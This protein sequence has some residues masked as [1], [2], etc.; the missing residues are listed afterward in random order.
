MRLILAGA[1]VSDV[2]RLLKIDAFSHWLVVLPSVTRKVSISTCSPSTET[3]DVDE[4]LTEEE[5]VAER[6]M[7]EVRDEHVGYGSP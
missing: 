6:G 3:L 1:R 7:T 5:V 4:L 2:E